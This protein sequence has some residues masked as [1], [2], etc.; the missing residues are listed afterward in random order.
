MRAKCWVSVGPG[1]SIPRSVLTRE[2]RPA[3]QDPAPEAQRAPELRRAT[4]NGPLAAGQSTRMNRADAHP[5]EAAGLPAWCDGVAVVRFVPSVWIES[6]GRSVVFGYDPEGPRKMGVRLAA[7]YGVFFVAFLGSAVYSGVARSPLAIVG[8]GIGLAAFF[9][10]VALACWSIQ[11]DTEDGCA[12]RVPRTV[13]S[14]DADTV[15]VGGQAL[16]GREYAIV[17]SVYTLRM[18]ESYGCP[19]IKLSVVHLEAGAS[20]EP[21]PLFACANSGWSVKHALRKFT[22]ETGVD[23][24]TRRL[25]GEV[26][27]EDLPPRLLK[28]LRNEGV[29]STGGDGG[30]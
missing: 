10:F 8:I 21:M 14:R 3:S 1:S 6:D 7:A 30:G 26:W 17:H 16:R 12:K 4:N 29:F 11:R 19:R 2:P 27:G 24:Q 20:R 9:G 28:D 13:Y 25:T 5:S 22:H 23:T 18:P 15:T